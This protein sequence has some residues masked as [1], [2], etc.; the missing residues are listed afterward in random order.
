MREIWKRTLKRE[1]NEFVFA[2]L[3][4]NRFDFDGWDCG[5]CLTLWCG[6]STMILALCASFLHIWTCMRMNGII[7]VGGWI[8]CVYKHLCAW[9]MCL[10]MLVCAHIV[11]QDVFFLCQQA[12]A[13]ICWWNA[14]AWPV[15]KHGPRSLTDVQALGLQTFV[16]NENIG[17]DICTSSRLINR[18]RFEFEHIY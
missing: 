13:Q 18:Q 3:K 8:A 9:S 14:S 5:A 2:E 15:L 12:L 6:L 11:L 17:W 10:V 4:V 7:P 1:L 16:C